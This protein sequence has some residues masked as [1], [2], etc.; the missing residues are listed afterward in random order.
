MMGESYFVR[1]RHDSQLCARGPRPPG[2]SYPD[3]GVVGGATRVIAPVYMRQLR[4]P[5]GSCP[6]KLSDPQVWLRFP[7]CLFAP[8]TR[9]TMALSLAQGCAMTWQ[10]YDNFADLQQAGEF[11]EHHC[12]TFHAVSPIAGFQHHVMLCFSPRTETGSFG[13]GQQFTSSSFQQLPGF[14]HWGTHAYFK[15]SGFIQQLLSNPFHP[16]KAR[17]LYYHLVLCTAPI[18]ITMQANATVAR[19]QF[20][21]V[22][23]PGDAAFHRLF[24]SPLCLSSHAF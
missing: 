2:W 20:L 17:A 14:L 10:D 23:Q 4:V 6:A 9:L 12:M 22:L 21:N 16:V 24:P 8:A 7:S 1:P 18:V 3:F 11:R 5:K 19:Q 13:V 15:P